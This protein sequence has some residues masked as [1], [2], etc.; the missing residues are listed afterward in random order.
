[1]LLLIL[2]LL[3]PLVL[4]LHPCNKDTI[5]TALREAITPTEDNFTAARID[6]YI[7]AKNGKCIFTPLPFNGASLVTLCDSNRDGIVNL[8]DWNNSTGCITTMRTHFREICMFFDCL[9]QE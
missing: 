9:N 4:S 3:S 7:A 8:V 1:M 2:L 5:Y 6:A